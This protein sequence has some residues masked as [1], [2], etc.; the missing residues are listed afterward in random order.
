MTRHV[1]PMQCTVAGVPVGVLRITDQMG[2]VWVE[3]SYPGRPTSDWEALGMRSRVFQVDAVFQGISWY[4]DLIWLKGKIEDGDAVIFVHPYWGTHIG[5]ISDF[6]VTHQDRRE[7]YAEARFTFRQ[8][9][10]TAF[11][12]S[13]GASLSTAAAAV[14]SSATS[15]SSALAALP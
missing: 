3:H 14:Y 7:D 6:S 1:P 13:T 8:G 2:Q 12:F 15:A 5:V 4:H 9:N 10:Q 11:S